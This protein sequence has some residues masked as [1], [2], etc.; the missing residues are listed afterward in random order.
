ML[1][2]RV[3]KQTQE[4]LN[5]GQG[6]AGAAAAALT[7][8][9][10]PASYG[11]FIRNHDGANA[12]YV[13]NSGLTAANGFRLDAGDDIWIPVTDPREVYVIRATADVAYSFLVV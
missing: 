10:W 12:M 2:V 13:G 9:P 7:T 1:P 3:A 4:K 8:N 5:T 6:T 11:I